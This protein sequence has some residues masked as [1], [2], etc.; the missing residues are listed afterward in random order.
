M[1]DLQQLLSSVNPDELN[2]IKDV[3]LSL[4]N[5]QGNTQ[6]QSDSSKDTDVA[7][8]L[9]PVLTA[10]SKMT[11]DDDRIKLILHLKPLLSDERKIRADNA[12]KFL[13]IMQIL[14]ELKG[15]L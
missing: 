12:I 7:K 9:E 10:I 11:D 13:H 1:T 8:S 3:A 6:T 15:L 2:K 14:P 4:V 5:G